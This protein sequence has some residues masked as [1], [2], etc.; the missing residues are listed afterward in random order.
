MAVASWVFGSLLL[1]FMLGVFV[2]GPKKLPGYKHR[3]LALL[4]ALLAGLFGFFLSGT[5]T[6]EIAAQLSTGLKTGINATGAMS[7]FVVVLFWWFS[8]WAR[9]GLQ[10]EEPQPE[11]TG[12]DHMK[13]GLRISHLVGREHVVELDLL[14]EAVT[15]HHADSDVADHACLECGPEHIDKVL[16]HLRD[17]LSWPVAKGEDVARAGVLDTKEALYAF[18]AAML[19][20]LKADKIE[21]LLGSGKL[22]YGIKNSR[23]RIRRVALLAVDVVE[24]HPGPPGRG[25]LLAAHAVRLANLLDVGNREIASGAR[26]DALDCKRQSVLKFQ[27][28]NAETRII[29]LQ[30]VPY[31]DGRDEEEVL[32]HWFCGE[33]QEAVDRFNKH[34]FDMD[35]KVP[36]WHL[37]VHNKPESV[38]TL[39]PV[40]GK[41]A[42]VQLPIFLTEFNDACC[43]WRTRYAPS[44]PMPVRMMGHSLRSRFKDVCEPEL[45]ERMKGLLADGGIKMQVLLLDPHVEG[46]EMREVLAAQMTTDDPRDVKRRIAPK[47]DTAFRIETSDDDSRGDIIES[48]AAI[49]E[50]WSRALGE[51]ASIEV[52]LTTRL[53]RSTMNCFGRRMVVGAY[54]KGGLSL[55]APEARTVEGT[56][57]F[58]SAQELFE[59]IWNDRSNTRLALCRGAFQEFPA[60]EME[61]GAWSPPNRGLKHTEPRDWIVGTGSG[62]FRAPIVLLEE[63]PENRVEL[64]DRWHKPEG[65]GQDD[66]DPPPPFEVEFQPS[67]VCQLNCLHCIGRRLGARPAASEGL[68]PDDNWKSILE[69][70]SRIRVSGLFGEPL[71]PDIRDQTNKIIDE[72]EKARKARQESNSSLTVGV[73]T[74]GMAL[75][76]DEAESKVVP[77]LLKA[78]YVH[79]S[80]DAGCSEVFKDLKR[81]S[82]F[83][84]SDFDRLVDAIHG[85]RREQAE[86]ELEAELTLGFV[87]TQ[88]NS[89]N[90]KNIF[91]VINRIGPHRA[92]FRPDLGGP[93]ALSWHTWLSLR[94]SLENEFKAGLD[95]GVL[96]SVSDVTWHE[97]A[98]PG[99]D[100]C[101]AQQFFCTVGPD[102]CVYPCDHQSIPGLCSSIGDLRSEDFDSI[103]KRA[104]ANGHGRRR[105]S[106]VLC[107]PFNW[108][109]NRFM[110]ER[111]ALPD[112]C[113]QL[114]CSRH[115]KG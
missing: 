23:T 80:L 59:D 92:R 100:R 22:G 78:N 4:N 84:E 79:L 106:C 25:E 86:S 52:R 58:T 96:M 55:Q 18:A 104:W 60:F 38:G 8:P 82:G 91:E 43:D 3:L 5:V 103:W 74:N 6:A 1:L 44:E 45:S 7:L 64:W 65:N 101:A 19:H 108:Q 97:C 90:L 93:A 42:E 68:P 76:E 71:H 81:P 21:R 89:R 56:P 12:R 36:R 75:L 94:D 33:M 107:P 67:A 28:L 63:D 47:R 113:R 20:D 72:A 111:E 85:L 15:A 48:I 114:V 27:A 31:P 10:R 41:M 110:G 61:A 13:N 39:F 95:N 115:Q 112:E 50:D 83:S 73:F 24:S 62:P 77:W 88:R 66:A 98:A 51:H 29:E 57:L 109:T 30:W 105:S 70:A 87:M 9:I 46:Q 34:L 2:L 49:E 69:R 102:W 11:R 99:D 35:R 37:E 53:M 26:P 17:L 16:E 32:R 54:G 40:S 14:Y